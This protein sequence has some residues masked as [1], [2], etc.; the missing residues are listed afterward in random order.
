MKRHQLDDDFSVLFL[1]DS[2]H[3][4]TKSFECD[5]AGVLLVGKANVSI[6]APSTGPRVTNHPIRLA[7]GVLTE[8]NSLD[9]VVGLVIG[10]VVQ[11]DDTTSVRLPSIIGGHS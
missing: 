4:N 5:A 7:S 8:S 11:G 2:L 6:F 9:S 1:V 3:F 10:A